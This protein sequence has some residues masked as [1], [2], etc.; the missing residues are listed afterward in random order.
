MRVNRGQEFVIGGYTVGG[1]SLRCAD[2]R[3]LRGRP[4]AVRGA[5]AQRV[6][7]RDSRAAVQALQGPGDYACPFANLP[8]KKAGDGARAD[9]KKM[10]DCRWMSRMLVGQFEFLEWTGDDHLRHSKFIALSD[11]KDPKAVVREKRS[12]G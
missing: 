5:H 2:L 6:H 10:P 4:A 7:A 11:D 8:E 12:K 3:L 9:A 1:K